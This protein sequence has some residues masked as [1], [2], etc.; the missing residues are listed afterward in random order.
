MLLCS[1]GAIKK[2]NKKKDKK[3]KKAA[4]V[5]DDEDETAAPPAEEPTFEVAGDDEWPEDEVKPKKGKK[6]KV[7]PLARSWASGPAK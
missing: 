7:S 3:G 1:Q 6:G 5:E 4:P 2:S